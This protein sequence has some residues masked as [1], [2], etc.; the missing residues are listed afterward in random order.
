MRAVAILSAALL[1][2][3]ALVVAARA[4]SILPEWDPVARKLVWVVVAYSALG[5]VANSVT[6][7]RWERLVWLPVVLTMLVCSLIVAIS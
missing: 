2:V 6:P 1:I 4:G 7:S 3:F 5:V